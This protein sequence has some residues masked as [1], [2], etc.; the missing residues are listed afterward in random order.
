MP[1]ILLILSLLFR[2]ETDAFC[3]ARFPGPRSGDFKY[4][5]IFGNLYPTSVFSRRL[6]NLTAILL[7]IIT[8]VQSQS[9][10]FSSSSPNSI[11]FLLLSSSSNTCFTTVLRV[12]W[13]RTLNLKK[14]WPLYGLSDYQ[15]KTYLLT[16]PYS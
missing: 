11:R 5:Y 3:T 14:E 12:S 13:F 4:E 2:S 16:L 1:L 9:D 15:L 10:D 7:P 8:F 6:Q